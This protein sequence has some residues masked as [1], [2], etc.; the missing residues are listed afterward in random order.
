L[1]RLIKKGAEADIYEAKWYGY[2]AIAK[3]RRAKNYRNPQLDYEVRKRRTLREAKLMINA[4]SVGV[5]TPLIFFVDPK[6]TEIV[7]QFIEGIRLKELSL[8]EKDSALNYYKQVGKNIALLHENKIIHGDL[9][10]SN[11]IISK[12]K[13]FLIDFGLAFSSNDLEDKAVDLHLMKQVLSSQHYEIFE[14]SFE[15]LL[16]GYESI[17]GKE[18]MSSIMRK[19]KEIEQRGRY[20][21]V[22]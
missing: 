9:T 8:L 16:E 12:D 18:K 5:P 6:N 2:R 1:E 17:V 19:I 22:V 10:T 3:I 21:R 20:A 11:F 13:P 14:K 7:M 15:F 4:R